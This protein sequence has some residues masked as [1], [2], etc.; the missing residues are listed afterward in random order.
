LGKW[1]TLISVELVAKVEEKAS[2]LTG[3]T[4]GGGE[5]EVGGDQEVREIFCV[6]V[7]RDCFVVTGG[8][9]VLHHSAVVG[10]EPERTEDSG[11]HGG[12][13]GAQVMDREESLRD[14]RDFGNVE[15]RRGSVA[16]GDD[17]AG[18][19]GGVRDEIVVRGGRILGRAE[20]A[21]VNDRSLKN[22]T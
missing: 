22:A 11:I 9:G 20:R 6:N 10:G 1:K 15:V 8:A 3:E 13:G 2:R 21:S 19:E 16:N 4:T 5:V 12:V 18:V 7:A 17:G 14:G